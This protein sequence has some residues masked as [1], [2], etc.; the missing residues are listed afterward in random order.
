MSDEQD[1]IEEIQ[2]G[3]AW[4]KGPYGPAPPGWERSDAP[5]RAKDELAFLRNQIRLMQP[6]Q[7]EAAPTMEWKNDTRK[8]ASGK[9]L[10]LGKWVVGG[11]HYDSCRSK[12]DPKKYDATCELPGIKKLLGHF[13]SSEEA[14]AAV[15]RAVKHWL[16]KLPPTTTT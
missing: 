5:F 9:L 7:I 1:I 10:C 4:A 6:Q 13:V 12:D 16:S 8:Y 3:A 11:A 2:S 15:E 14:Q